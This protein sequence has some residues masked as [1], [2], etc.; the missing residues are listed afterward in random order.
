MGFL[1]SSVMRFYGMGLFDA[2]ALPLNTFWELSRNIDRVRAEEDRRLFDL[3]QNA[4]VGNPR[5]YAQRLEQERGK[6]IEGDMPE[7]L[8]RDGFKRLKALAGG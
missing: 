8:D 5:K 6:V 7:T 3:L 4:F 2:R 1:V